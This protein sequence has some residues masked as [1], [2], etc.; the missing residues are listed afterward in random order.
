MTLID[1][2]FPPK[3][4]PVKD[5][6]IPKI[7]VLT[8]KNGVPVYFVKTNNKEISEII[9][10][11]DAGVWHQPKLL[12]ASM[13][14]KLLEEGTKYKT[15][16]Q[17]ADIFDFYGAH[18]DSNSGMHASSVK[19]MALNKHFPKL[20][21]LVEEILTYP[22]FSQKEFEIARNNSKQ[23]LII[24]LDEED[25]IARNKLEFALFGEEYPY[26]WAAN[27]EDYDK[28]SPEILKDFFTKN[29]V[30]EKLSIVVASNQKDE[31]IDLLNKH[32]GNF[33]QIKTESEFSYNCKQSAKKYTLIEKED[34]LQSAVRIGWKMFDIKHDDNI[35][36][37]ILD[38]FLGGYFGSRLMQ[39]IRQKK[40]YTY[41]IYSALI[42]FKYNGSFQ[43]ISEVKKENKFKVVE[44]I[45]KEIIRLQT[46]LISDE[47]LASLR[48][49][50]MGGLLR[51]MNG[52]FTF[53]RTLH[54]FLVYDLGLNYI[55][56][57]AERIQNITPERLQQLAQDYLKLDEMFT[58]IVG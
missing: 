12:V 24:S 11:F 31:I 26:G 48:N 7:E 6:S 28:L 41:S 54:S 57:Y 10:N 56:K 38:T 44:E 22:E 17:I 47:E 13:A 3:F 42:S 1:R 2:R 53:A 16:K 27:P 15:S 35:D 34:A 8:L 29:F 58:V 33:R 21:E 40:G 9:L 55:E 51:G 19:L 20:V 30:A 49:Y 45:K 23:K 4:E 5:I 39:N 36:M 46:E 37:S 50:M 14:Q 18:F 32:F 43:I 52:N 25:V